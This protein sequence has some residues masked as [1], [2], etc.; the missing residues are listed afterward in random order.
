MSEGLYC[1]ECLA[2]TDSFWL[3]GNGETVFDYGLCKRCAE[4]KAAYCSSPLVIQ[5]DECTIITHTSFGAMVHDGW[6][7]GEPVE[8]VGWWHDDKLAVAKHRAR[9][10]VTYFE[11]CGIAAS[12]HVYQHGKRVFTAELHPLRAMALAKDPGPQPA[13]AASLS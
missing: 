10:S 4:S 6:P 8:V 9:T 12:R 7:T 3:S 2:K 1:T 13:L 5:E 11:R